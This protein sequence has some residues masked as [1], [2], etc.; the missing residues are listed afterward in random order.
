MFGFPVSVR[1]SD[2]R[3]RQN[4]SWNDIVGR[5]TS[6]AHARGWPR[7]RWRPDTGSVSL[8]LAATGP[9]SPRRAA[10][11][12]P[13]PGHSACTACTWAAVSRWSR[14]PSASAWPCHRRSTAQQHHEPRRGCRRR[15]SGCRLRRR[16]DDVDEH[17]PSCWFKRRG[18]RVARQALHHVGQSVAALV[19]SAAEFGCSVGCL[20]R[21]R[22]LGHRLLRGALLAHR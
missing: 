17:V 21:H 2:A 3:L 12:A 9:W 4:K 16:S 14:A 11:S 5:D 22:R 18:R 10:R 13:S 8:R 7:C 15:T 6:V 1:R 20:V 19:L